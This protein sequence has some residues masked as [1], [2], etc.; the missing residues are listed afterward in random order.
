MKLRQILI[1]YEI[2]NNLTHDDM[3]KKIGIGRST[4]FR[5]LSGESQS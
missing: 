4:Y 3:I 2:E 1:Q 5:W